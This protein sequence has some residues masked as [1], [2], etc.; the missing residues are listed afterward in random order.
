MGTIVAH[1]LLLVEEEDTF[2]LM[3]CL[4]EDILPPTYYLSDFVGIRIDTLVLSNL[5]ST[6][7]PKIDELL[8]E[9]DI[10]LSLI[11]FNWFLSIFASVVHVKLLFRIWDLFFAE[12]DLVLF[13]VMLSMIKYRGKFRKYIFIYGIF[14]FIYLNHFQ[15]IPNFWN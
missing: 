14:K 5:V 7:F 9:H 8:K 6:H 10:D 2:W 15:Q 11:L 4:I 3:C 1:I 13:K 12:G